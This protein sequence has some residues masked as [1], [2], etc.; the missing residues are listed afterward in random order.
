VIFE[1]FGTAQVAHGDFLV[2]FVSARAESYPPQSRKPDVRPATLEED[3]RRRDFTC[4]TLLADPAGEVIDL[5]GQGLPDIEARLLHTPLPAAE[6]FAEDPL[7]AVRAVRFAVTLGFTMDA[8]IMPA[9]RANLDRLATVVSIERVNDELRKLLLSAR[10]G[11]GIRLLRESGILARLMPEIEAMHGVEQSGYHSMDVLEHTLSA[12][13]AVAGRP[14]PHLP[15]EQELVLRLGVLLHDVGKPSTAA[16]DGD[17]VT[18]LGHPDAGVEISRKLLRRLRF[19][20]AEIEATCALVRL[21]MRPIQYSPKVWG[22]SGVRRLVREA[23]AVLEPLLQLAWADMAASEY[24][25]DEAE[26]KLGDLRRRIEVL[27][28]EA[29]RRLRPP[30]DG[31]QLTQR[32]DRPPG[33]WVGRVQAALLE[34]VLD[35]ALP[36]GEGN[37]QAAW[38]Y[39]EGHPEL[40]RE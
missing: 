5:T 7:R 34:A 17:R 25:R 20:N 27:D 35:G 8:Q 32:Y 12:L 30:L 36:T 2:E 1:R 21:H 13:D 23:D 31:N 37:E 6:T 14:A 4:N 39:I 33:P 9:I 29:V 16:R 3:V 15:T 10:P 38:D 19:S 24:P 18:F 11:E 40:L 22:D 26:R 28:A